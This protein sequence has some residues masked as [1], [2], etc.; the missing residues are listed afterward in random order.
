MLRRTCRGNSLTRYLETFLQVTL[1]D[2]IEDTHFRRRCVG[3]VVTDI[4]HTSITAQGVLSLHD[5]SR[6]DFKNP[7]NFVEA[8]GKQTAEERSEPVDP[9]I[10][11]EVMSSDSGAERT[12][13]IQ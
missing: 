1:S 3:L 8:N 12:C 2:R 6:F 11:W 9:V 10:A 7:D 5:L 4:A 13:R